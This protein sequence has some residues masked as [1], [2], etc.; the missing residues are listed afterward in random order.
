M[1][2]EFNAVAKKLSDGSVVYDVVLTDEDND[3]FEP[4]TVME[5]A[6]EVTADLAQATLYIVLN[7]F[8]S[9]ASDQEVRDVASKIFVAVG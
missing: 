3:G 2:I 6:S 4:V 7:R 5:A 1:D 8:L 9:C